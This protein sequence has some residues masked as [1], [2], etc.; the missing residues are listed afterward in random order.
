MPDKLFVDR[1]LLFL[2]YQS[3]IAN[4]FEFLCSRWMNSGSLPRNPSNHPEGLGFDMIVGQQQF[5]RIRNTY[6]RLAPAGALD[7]AVTNKSLNS[8]DWVLATGG[9]Y[10]F[11]PS[12][13]AMSTVLA[14]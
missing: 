4:Q 12:I 7:I 11:A 8:K 2:S 6:L 1:G 10:F 13:S 9:G 14:G 3:S 5:G